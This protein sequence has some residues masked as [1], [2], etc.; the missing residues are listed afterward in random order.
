MRAVAFSTFGGP[1]VLSVVDVPLPEPRDGEVRIRVR[2]APVQPADLAARSGAFGPMLPTGPTYVPGWDVAGVVDA[3]GPGVRDLTPGQPV[4]GLSDW[5]VTRVGTHAEFVVLPGS[6]LAPP[7]AGTTPTEAATLPAN[8][9]TAAQALDLLGLTEGQTLAVTGA[10]GAVGGYAVEL[11][12]LRGLRVLAIGAAQDETFLT[13]RD[14]IFVPRGDEPARAVRAVTPD[15]VDGLLDAAVLGA[16]VLGAVRDGGGYVGVVAPAAPPAERQVRVKVVG[17]RS[18][19]GRLRE[20]VRLVEQGR[21][22]P[23]VADVLPFAQAAEAHARFA[24]GG[25]RGRVVL[26]P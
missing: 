21:L 7:P 22:T 6:A 25:L 12:R 1:E 10:G 26:V 11:A 3:V 20:L 19:G 14:A 5:L 4:L 16:G 8:A 13:A 23:R 9:L 15:G 2:A 17:L 24:R 18:D